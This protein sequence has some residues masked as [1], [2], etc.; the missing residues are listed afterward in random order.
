MK[1][2]VRPGRRVRGFSLLEALVALAIAAL[3]FAALY[4]AVGQSAY[5]A[6]VLDERTEAHV[7]A[8]SILASATFAEDFIRHPSGAQDGWTWTIQVAPEQM[9]LIETGGAQDT[10][11]VRAARVTLAVAHGGRTVLTWTG[12]KPYGAAS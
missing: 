8:R 1:T 2:G 5:N 3:A 4:R 7:L 9:Q 10:L 12:W 11:A 6:T